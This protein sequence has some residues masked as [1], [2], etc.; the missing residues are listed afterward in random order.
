MRIKFK[1]SDVL[2]TVPSLVASSILVHVIIN[3]LFL[4]PFFLL[5]DVK[6]TQSP[7]ENNPFKHTCKKKENQLLY[8]N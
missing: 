7:I 3:V 1:I 8:L 4:R 6:L 2:W 5:A